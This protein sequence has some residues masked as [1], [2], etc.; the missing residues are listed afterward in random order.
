MKA[1]DA[2]SQPIGAG[3]EVAYIARRGRSVYVE[4]RLIAEIQLRE[5]AVCSRLAPMVR[6]V[7][8]PRWANTYNCVRIAG[9][10]QEVE[11]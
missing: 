10:V 1:F 6:F 5:S 11:A 4:R 7:G 2:V 9:A 3:D 8:S